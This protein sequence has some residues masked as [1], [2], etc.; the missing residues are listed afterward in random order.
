LPAAQD[1]LPWATFRP[2]SV[3]FA[4]QYLL[5]MKLT[6]LPLVLSALVLPCAANA[7][8]RLFLQLPVQFGSGV[9]LTE[10]FKAECELGNE[11]VIQLT[12]TSF[13][14]IVDGSWAGSKAMTVMAEL[15]QGDTV[16]A[17]KSVS[18]N[19]RAST[20]KGNCS[21]LGK[22]TGSIAGQ[23]GAWVKRGMPQE[24]PSTDT[25]TEE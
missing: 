1:K 13:P 18:R 17:S 21:R 10:K 23:I 24:A 5:K 7:A 25:E 2:Y 15:K 9:E 20:V 8:D 22:Y 19:L 14:Q 11:K 12:V 3:E 6:Y 16:L 4:T